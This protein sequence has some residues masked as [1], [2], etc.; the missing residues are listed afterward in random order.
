MV[1]QEYV[2]SDRTELII[3]TLFQAYIL[4]TKNVHFYMCIFLQSDHMEL[5][6]TYA[7]MNYDGLVCAFSGNRAD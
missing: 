3:L 4:K 2:F 7:T 6:N 5:E 1:L